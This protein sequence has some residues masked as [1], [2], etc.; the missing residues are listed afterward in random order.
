LVEH[1]RPQ[2]VID[3]KKKRQGEALALSG[4]GSAVWPR[5]PCL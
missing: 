5:C 1:D 4:A 3:G 2:A